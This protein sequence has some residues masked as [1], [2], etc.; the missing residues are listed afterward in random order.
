MYCVLRP[1]VHQPSLKTHIDTNTNQ[2]QTKYFEAGSTVWSPLSY[3][4][5]E[6]VN[7]TMSAPFNSFGFSPLDFTKLSQVTSQN[8]LCYQPPTETQS[9]PFSLFNDDSSK[10]WGPPVPSKMETPARQPNGTT[11]VPPGGNYLQ[12]ASSISPI[13]PPANYEIDNSPPG[14]EHTFGSFDDSKTPIPSSYE[15]LFKQLKTEEKKGYDTVKEY[16]LASM[17]LLP[18][19]LHWRMYVEL[20]DIA[21]RE[22]VVKD[23]RE[24]Y[25]K[26]VLLHPHASQIWLEYAKL[27]DECGALA[28]CQKILSAA[29]TYCPFNEGLMVKAIKLEEKLGNLQNARAILARLKYVSLEKG[30]RV[31]LEGGLFEA[32]AG[33]TD[34]ARKIFKFLMK[35]AATFG[36]VFQEACMLE[37]RCENYSKAI[38]IA[39]KGLEENPRYGPLYLTILRLHE[40]IAR[41]DLSRTREVVERAIRF[42]PKELKWKIH[43]EA[44]LIEDR[45][46]DLTRS[47]EC[48]VSSVAHCP[49]NLL[50]KVWLA[51]ARTELRAK[52]ISIARK[53]LQRALQDV[54]QKKKAQVW[55]EWAHLEEFVGDVE[56][57]RKVLLEAKESASHEWKVFLESIL[58]E[59]RAHNLEA[60]LEE[61]R[62][63]LEI[64][65][66]TGRLWALL[67]QLTQCQGEEAQLDVFKEALQE[68]PKSGEVWCEGARI[69]LAK[70]EWKEAR[71]YLDFAVHFTPQFGDSFIEFLRLEMWENG[72]SAD[73]SQLELWCT[74]AEPNYGTLWMYCKRN[75][76]DSTQKVL[77]TA[78]EMFEAHGNDGG[79]TIMSLRFHPDPPLSIEDRWRLI[80]GCDDVKP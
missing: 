13:E 49:N 41:R 27:E 70:G 26:A 35:N 58:L 25:K 29:L 53:L 65:S 46:G 76:L 28:K 16:G 38:E 9:Q 43:Y 5:Y 40:K 50:W 54:P 10:L 61:C 34:V 32:R 78:R 21:K 71:K 36:N 52:K 6:E 72:P 4:Q 8:I 77:Q 39:E 42:I 11:F 66:G 22:S 73:L 37:E 45:A 62:Q 80:F 51:G 63:A 33:N 74:N 64:H 79:E 75:P 15:Y 56:K 7:W 68:V 30:W 3:F 57:A 14:M 1:D 17:D 48:Y 67:I 23:A 59:I 12:K 19:R 2:I 20:A 31:M 60:A 24:F 44:A 18:S 69:H 55:L 47:R